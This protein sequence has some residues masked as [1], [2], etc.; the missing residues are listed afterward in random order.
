MNRVL[1]TAEFPAEPCTSYRVECEESGIGEIAVINPGYGW[2]TGVVPTVTVNTSGSGFGFAATVTMEC[3]PGENFCSIDDITIDNP[4]EEYFYLDQLSVNISPLPSC[5][6]N[7]LLIDGNFVNGFLNWDV[8][9]AVDSWLLTPGMVPYYNIPVYGSIGGTI[10]QSILTPGR[11]YLIDFEKVT[12][13]ARSGT[14]R[15]IVS[16]GFFSITGT[17]SNQYMI[18]RN[19]GDPDFDGPLSITLTCFGSTIFSIYADSS[20]TD[21]LN[22]ARLTAVSVIELCEVI[23]PELDITFLDGCGPFIIPNCD[24][25][26][27]PTQ[28]EI[29][30]TPE[31]AI[32]VCAGGDGPSAILG[33]L[34]ITPNPE[35]IPGNIC[36]NLGTEAFGLY[37][38]SISPAGT[39]NGKNYY[40]MVAPDCVTPYDALI[41]PN[42]WTV[43]YSTGNGYVGQWVLSEGLDQY[44]YVQWYLPVSSSPDLPL[45]NWVIGPDSGAIDLVSTDTNCQVSCCNCV[46]YE[47]INTDIIET[48]IDFYYTSCEDQSVVAASINSQETIQICAVRSS[49]W[50]VATKDNQFL[51]VVLSGIQDC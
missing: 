14:V 44:I 28:Y 9:P 21:S 17:A 19:S 49:V 7:E 18:T 22:L 34:N 1:F 4:G 27:N 11:T 8:I 42:V 37:T 40:L 51:E 48:P 20:T 3:L 25:S 15:F 13:Q 32:N 12:V 6:S 46:K 16:A 47:V 30:G 45:G 39:H 26:A 2:P 38:C 23:E 41:A 5:E 24:G 31:Y 33:K 36:F 10:E 35:P 50:P 29:Q 43:W